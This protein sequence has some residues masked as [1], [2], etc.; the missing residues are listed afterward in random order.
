MDLPETLA[1]AETSVENPSAP[2]SVPAQRGPADRRQGKASLTD[3]LLAVAAV[4]EAIVEGGTSDRLLCLMAD[5]ARQLVD[6]DV[7]LI[8]L[9]EGATHL[10]ARAAEGADAEMLRDMHLPV[11]GSLAGAVLRS[12]TARN[13][14][15]VA[16]E[17]QS[18]AH[19]A[20]TGH[21]GPSVLVPLKVR[22]HGVAVIQV[23]NRIGFRRFSQEEFQTLQLF[24]AQIGLAVE[25]HLSVGVTLLDAVSLQ[26]CDTQAR[27]DLERLAPPPVEMGALLMQTLDRLART[28]VELSH[29]EACC[30]QLLDAERS[31][32]RGGAFGLQEELVAAMNAACRRGAAHPALEAVASQHCVVVVNERERILADARFEA[33][34]DLARQL[35]W[36]AVGCVPLVTHAGHRGAVCYYFPAGK[37]PDEADLR[38][39]KAMAAQAGTVVDNAQLLAAANKTV[40]I[41]ER[42]HL[43]REL[44]DS[45]SQALYGIALGAHA[46]LEQLEH[47]PA[48]A[49]EPVQY[50]LQLAE[51]ALAEMRAVIFELRAESLETEGLA[52]AIARQADV[53]RARNGID[54]ELTVEGVPDAPVEAH[55]A[56]YRIGQEALNNAAKHSAARHVRVRLSGDDERVT[57]E[58]ADDGAG[59]D[60]DATFPGHLGLHSMR[61]RAAA[62]GG[63]VRISSRPG[64]GTRV[65]AAVPRS[66]ELNRLGH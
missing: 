25:T 34:H 57:L 65:R 40:A 54:V 21:L 3:R 61:E 14:A 33:A 46:T 27:A 10:R 15:D 55:Q 17:P 50:V 16:S 2:P 36:D 47:D 31:L 59:F 62:V 29:V 11:R 51:T 39:I 30:I 28:V 32:R 66:P 53:V 23:A 64:A 56:L 52:A 20:V 8:L 6:G 63:T 1:L 48:R 5:K 13:V 9:P 58:V 60:P 49:R 19:L 43:A 7:C 26:A 37:R 4:T 38:L 12:G 35:P 41:E 42:Q 44:H 18:H 45:V 24:A 22:A